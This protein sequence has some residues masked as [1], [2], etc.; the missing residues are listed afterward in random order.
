MSREDVARGLGR[1]PSRAVN[2]RDRRL[3]ND[4]IPAI[5]RVG[6]EHSAEVSGIPKTT[7]VNYLSGTRPKFLFTRTRD[8]LRKLLRYSPDPEK[9]QA[10]K[11][12]R[13]ETTLLG[14]GI[15]IVDALE[16]IAVSLMVIAERDVDE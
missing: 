2:N 4:A 12:S 15:R 10:K 11:V 16:L 5:H 13:A 1:G 9:E 14:L 3:I 7:L 6:I 8:G